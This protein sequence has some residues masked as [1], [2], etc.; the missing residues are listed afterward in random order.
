VRNAWRWIVVLLWLLI[1]A[2]FSQQ[3]FQQQDI[4]PY[5]T[6]HPRLTHLIQ[7]LPVIQFH[8]HNSLI[9]SHSN[10]VQFV[11]FVVRKTM[12]I[13]LYG[14]FGL[15]LLL[16]LASGRRIKLRHWAL[17]ALIILATAALDEF[18]Q[19]LSTSRTGCIE[20]IVMDFFGYILFS[21][22]LLIK[23]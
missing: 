12:H 10:S 15:S 2:Y 3:P 5:I 1:I 22:V 19:Y 18:N 13:T 16:A 17:A 14:L 21:I 7:Q 23:R 11:Q 9:N 20:D 8:Y 4:S 6:D